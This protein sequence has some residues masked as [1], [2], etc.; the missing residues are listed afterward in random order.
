MA[1]LSPRPAAACI[2]GGEV[3]DEMNCPSCGGYC[4][5][6]SVDVGI[7]II[8]GPYGCTECGWSEWEEYDKRNGLSKA[9][10]EQPE[11]LFD[12]RGGMIRKESFLNAQLSLDDV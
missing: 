11:Y 10:M 9:E 1:L 2:G 7:G 5:R 3:S 8:H 4:Y 6:D 12:T